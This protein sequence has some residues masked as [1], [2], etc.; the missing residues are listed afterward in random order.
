MPI[1]FLLHRWGFGQSI[2]SLGFTISQGMAHVQVQSAQIF[3]KPKAFLQKQI[4]NKVFDMKNTV[5]LCSVV[6]KPAGG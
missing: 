1:T 4:D 5:L 6:F 3:L 2:S